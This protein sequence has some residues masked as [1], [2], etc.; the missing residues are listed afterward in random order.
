M[1]HGE[2]AAAVLRKISGMADHP[3]GKRLKAM[4][5][6]MLPWYA[7]HLGVPESALRAKVLKISAA[8]IARLLASE[9][10][11]VQN[12][13]PSHRIPLNLPRRAPKKNL[14]YT[15]RFDAPGSESYRFLGKMLASSLVKT[16]ITGRWW[17]SVTLRRRW[18]WWSGRG[19]RKSSWIRRTCMARSGRSSRGAGNIG[20]LH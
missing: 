16:F 1:V 20:W 6:E 11:Q 18:F 3:C 14:I 17:C 13:Y 8:Q 10:P 15:G 9:R 4:V 12:L 5:P 19:W 7:I 2:D